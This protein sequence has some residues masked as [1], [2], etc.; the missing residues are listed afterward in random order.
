MKRGTASKDILSAREAAGGEALPMEYA[1]R[2]I[3]DEAHPV[4]LAR[5]PG[6]Y[7]APL[8]ERA[9]MQPGYVAEIEAGKKVGSVDAYRKL[10]AVLNTTLDDLLRLPWKVKLL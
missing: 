3:M 6:P 10:A 1:R 2:I 9:G 5:I 7:P 8:A 4:R